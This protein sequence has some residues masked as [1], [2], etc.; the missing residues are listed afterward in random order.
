M[1]ACVWDA[2]P[3]TANNGTTFPILIFHSL[4]CDLNQAVI[5]LIGYYVP[6]T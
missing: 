2:V 1:H 5:L 4:I 3:D 6:G